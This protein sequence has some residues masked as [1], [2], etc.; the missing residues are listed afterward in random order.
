MSNS[1]DKLRTCTKTE[2]ISESKKSHNSAKILDK[3]YVLLRNPGHGD[4]KQVLKISTIYVKKVLSKCR[5]VR[6]T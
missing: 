5:L 4:G 1:F 6:K 2:P 3:S